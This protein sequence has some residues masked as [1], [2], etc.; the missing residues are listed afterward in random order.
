M[1]TTEH[2]HA[3]PNTTRLLKRAREEAEEL[4][5]MFTCVVCMEEKPAVHGK[6]M[7]CCAARGATDKRGH[8]R[9]LCTGDC[10]DTWVERGGGPHCPTC[11]KSW[12]DE[13]PRG[14]WL[15]RHADVR[16]AFDEEEEYLRSRVSS[17]VTRFTVRMTS[18]EVR[19]PFGAGPSA[20]EDGEDDVR[21]TV[22][23]HAVALCPVLGE[24]DLLEQVDI[25]EEERSL[26][27]RRRRAVAH[28]HR[29]ERIERLVEERLHAGPAPDPAIKLRTAAAAYKL[30]R[31]C[32]LACGTQ[33]LLDVLVRARNVLFALRGL[34]QESSSQY[35]PAP[36]GEMLLSHYLTHYCTTTALE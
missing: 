31:V 35:P 18:L 13:L 15:Q 24:E 32:F 30:A 29:E 4:E 8:A 22:E 16:R 11:R 14:K 9:N 3:T 7:S 20:A 6:L 21:L 33:E 25:T 34:P 12:T 2:E 23:E 5:D 10:F 27:K 1:A 36:G 19:P 28:L 17:A 26:A